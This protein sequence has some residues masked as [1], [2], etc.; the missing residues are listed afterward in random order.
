VP[1]LPFRTRLSVLFAAPAR[2]AV[3]L[4]RGPKTH[5][6]LIAWDLKDDSFRIGQWM[7]GHVH[8]C[9]LSPDG[10]TLIYWAAQYRASAEARRR[11]PVPFDPPQQSRDA[12]KKRRARPGRKVP[13]YLRPLAPDITPRENTGTWTAIST[14]P[15]SPRWRPISPRWRI[16]RLMVIGPAAVCLWEPIALCCSNR[17]ITWSPSRTFRSPRGF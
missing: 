16:G 10:R 2:K 8:L 12:L 4:R 5:Y 15:Y 17:R 6:C 7:K 13:R 1:D 9:D 3:L 14:V 11:Q